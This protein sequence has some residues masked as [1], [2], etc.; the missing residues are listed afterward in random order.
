MQVYIHKM[1]SSGGPIKTLRAFQRVDIDAGKTN[2]ITIVLPESAFEF[3]DRTSGKMTV[4]SG[5]YEIL[6]EIS[7]GYG[8]IKNGNEIYR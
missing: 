7:K 6:Y 2:E 3:F 4:T 1:N 5:D 8:F